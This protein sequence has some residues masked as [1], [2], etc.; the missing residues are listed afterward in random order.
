MPVESKLDIHRIFRSALKHAVWTDLLSRNPADFVK[1][2]KA[3][4]SSMQA[5]GYERW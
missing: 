5:D 4:K 2:P 3:R 1:P